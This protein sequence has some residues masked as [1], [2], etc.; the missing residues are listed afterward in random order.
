[1]SAVP[2][3]GDEDFVTSSEGADTHH[4]DVSIHCLLGHLGGGLE[5]RKEVSKYKLF[6]NQ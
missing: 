6:L 5:E 2:H 3:L 4:M 1:M